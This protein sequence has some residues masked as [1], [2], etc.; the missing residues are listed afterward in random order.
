M[1]QARVGFVATVSFRTAPKIDSEDLRVARD[2]FWR[3]IQQRLRREESDGGTP[4]KLESILLST[5]PRALHGLLMSHYQ[6]PAIRGREWVA[7]HPRELYAIFFHTA[8]EGYGSALL[9]VDV[10]GAKEFAEFLK[11][12]LDTFTML[13]ETFVPAAFA[14]VIPS[15]YDEND[16]AATI[17]PTAE[18]S[19][20]FAEAR[21]NQAVGTLTAS[22]SNATAGEANNGGWL[23]N[24]PRALVA[25]AFSL[26]TP[27]V[28][29][30]IVLYVA[31]QMMMQDRSELAKREATLISNEQNL[32]ET[33]RSSAVDLQK[34]NIELLRLL[35]TSQAG[36]PPKP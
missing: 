27:I 4:E 10:G 2:V 16:F 15:S 19:R 8:I 6:Y 3:P 17:A 24:V 30:L 23:R 22:S 31:A 28:L 9:A 12:N 35:R 32:R 26:L 36:P 5:F 1:D 18:L 11:G 14:A 7:G 33:E 34:E 20:I 29:S 25:T 13:M 21:A